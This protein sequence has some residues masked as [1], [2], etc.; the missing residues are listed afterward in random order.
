MLKM[1][2]IITYKDKVYIVRL[3]EFN[4]IENTDP[5]GCMLWPEALMCSNEIEAKKLLNELEEISFTMYKSW[6]Y[7]NNPDEKNS[8]KILFKMWQLVDFFQ[9]IIEEISSLKDYENFYRIGE[10]EIAYL[11]VKSDRSLLNDE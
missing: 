10:S 5:Y 1:K 6:F 7:E 4:E 8:D 11:K 2:D 3:K 9:Y